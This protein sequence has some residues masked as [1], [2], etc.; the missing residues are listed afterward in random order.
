MAARSER[1]TYTP[2]DFLE[3][4][5]AGSLVLSPKFQ[6]RHVWTTP[7]RSYL[8]DTLLLEMPVP[9]I[10]I[11]VV[12]NEKRDKVV[13]EVV[14]GQ[15]RVS[16]I[17]DFV[18]GKYALSK[19]IESPVS[20]KRF[21]ELAKEDK[22]KILRYSFI[23][24][25]F[26]GVEDAEVLSIFARLNTHSVKLNSQE[27]RNGK[28]FGHFKQSSYKLAFEHLELWRRFGIFTDSRIARM[29]EVELTSE[30]LVLGM[31][32]LQDK[33]KSLDD[34]YEEFDDLFPDRKRVEARF[35]AV[36]DSI[37]SCCEEII[38]SSEFRRPPLFYTLYG[39]VYHKL[40]GIPGLDL[41]GG[42]Q[43]R[44]TK[45]DAE[46]LSSAVR[47]LS[48]YISTAKSQDES[49]VPRKY[50]RFVS[51]CLRQTD[52]IKPRQV[53]LETLYEKAFGVV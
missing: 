6:R 21:Q 31:D 32:G 19:N 44:L 2:I 51:S 43:G 16:A 12:Q 47:E 4:Q 49:E 7:A 18:A 13:R 41:D 42:E 26:H 11:R 8:I 20:G 3:W 53:R 27:L 25:V 46:A 5:E 1:S 28:W 24:E 48:E 52:N 40:Y 22:D 38:P 17:L 30:L 10:Y 29:A 9:P 34:F 39:V 14:D 23:C 37:V 50:R 45:N 36:I 15:Q 35:R 33:K